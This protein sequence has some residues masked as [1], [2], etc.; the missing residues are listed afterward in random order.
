MADIKIGGRGGA[1]GLEYIGNIGEVW[2]D[3]NNQFRRSN[4]Q[5]PGGVLISGGAGAT[6]VSQLTDTTSLLTHPTYSIISDLTS[7]D[8]P[9][10]TTPYLDTGGNVALGTNSLNSV[11]TGAHNSVLGFDALTSNTT[12][13]DNVA[14]GKDAMRLNTTGYAM[15]A[16]GHS[17]LEL[18]TGGGYPKN[19]AI[20]YFALGLNETGIWNTAVGDSVL[21]NNIGSTTGFE[22]DYNT[23][24]GTLSLLKNTTGYSNTGIGAGTLWENTTGYRN[25]AVGIDALR[26]NTTGIKN[27]AIGVFAGRDV[28]GS[29]NVFLGHKAGYNETGSSK[30]HIA[31]SG[32]TTLIGGD[33]STGT[34]TFNEAYT[35]PSTDGTA[36][37]SLE[38]DGA[39]NVSW[40]SNNL[41]AERIFTI[42]TADF[43]AITG[44]RHAVDTTSSVVTATLSASPATGD[45]IFFAD[46]G[47]NYAINN[48][49]IGRNGNTIM[50]LSQDMTVSTDNQ[51]FGLFY[52]G[53]TWRTY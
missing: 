50:G 53:T 41:K 24:V 49:I 19:T 9:D 48:L 31:N 43:N 46:A 51:S 47:G 6:D 26:Y 36:G 20:G 29:Y 13:F 22:G 8:S 5:T 39:G 3:K 32:T 30:L 1:D 23:G 11:T 40:Q 27:T 34:V 4:G 12:G 14:I 52:N 7:T 10:W 38:T 15:T 35:F 18:Y 16:V 28:T 21:Y 45:A 37:E 2:I 33:F 17:A 42:Y 44:S 25:T